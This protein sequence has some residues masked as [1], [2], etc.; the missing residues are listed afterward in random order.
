MKINSLEITHAPQ[1]TIISINLLNLTYK[2]REY[3]MNV[4]DLLHRPHV[5]L[6]F[7][8]RQSNA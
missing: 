1:G 7:G 4:A 8:G 2:E 6:C 5:M 3:S